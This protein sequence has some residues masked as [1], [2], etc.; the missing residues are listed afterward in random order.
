MR[1]VQIDDFGSPGVLKIS[2]APES[3]PGP[4][5]FFVRFAA[6]TITPVDVKVRSGTE[7][8]AR[9][10]LPAVAAGGTETTCNR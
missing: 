3:A 1:D 2:D 8:P 6:C 5:E 7:R 4:A 9:S 10:P